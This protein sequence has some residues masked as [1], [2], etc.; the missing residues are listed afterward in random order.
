M[1]HAP[2][3]PI[4]DPDRNLQARIEADQAARIRA[5]RRHQRNAELAAFW[6]EATGAVLVTVVVMEGVRRAIN[7][8]LFAWLRF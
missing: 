3:R 5:H 7:A 6:Y 2:Y 8:G 1:I 4:S